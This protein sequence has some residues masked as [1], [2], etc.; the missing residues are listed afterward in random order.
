[1]RN[2][3]IKFK[4]NMLLIFNKVGLDLA[5]FS[6]D[7]I[8]EKWRS[9][10]ELIYKSNKR[11]ILIQVP[12]RDIRFLGP[13]GFNAGVNSNAPFVS[14][15]KEYVDGTAKDYKKS[16]L[17][18]FYSTFQPK[19]ISKYLYLDEAKNDILN[20]LPASGVFLP[21]EDEDPVI[22]I[23]KRA[24]Q[25]EDDNKEHKAD[26]M[27]SEGDPFYGPVSFEKGK[28]EYN[29]LINVYKSI[30]ENGFKVDLKGNNN[31][32][33]IILENNNRYRYFITAGQHRIAALSVLNYDFIPLQVFTG[34]IVRRSEVKF[35]PGV[36][37]E[38]FTESE[39]L[40]VFDDIFT[41][42]DR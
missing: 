8:Y 10:I 9:P 37:K 14:T 21:W 20:K 32:S 41:G 31:I 29:R 11:R 23:D 28:L 40:T 16:S 18:S 27:I 36:I 34:L 15:V 24:R 35:W 13:H 33:A 7:F 25:V 6:E 17:C 4:R 26:L 2:L 1:M 38:Y 19:S 3:I 12:V 30:A 22:K 39:A 42:R 5:T